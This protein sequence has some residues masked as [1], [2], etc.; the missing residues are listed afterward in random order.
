MFRTLGLALLLVI[1]AAAKAD[2]PALTVDAAKGALGTL[3][4]GEYRMV[5]IHPYTCC[6]V[7]VC[8]CLPCGCY[9]VQCGGGCCATKLVFNYPGFFNDVVIRFK[10]DG[11]V[12]V[13]D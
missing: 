6:P 13:K 12:A 5:F 7:E 8:F 10:K 3:P 1:S 2:S 4:P 11:T 9:E